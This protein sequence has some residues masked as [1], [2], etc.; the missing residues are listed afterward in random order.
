MRVRAKLPSGE[1]LAPVTGIHLDA[2]RATCDDRRARARTRRPLPARLHVR[3]EISY[4]AHVV[5]ACRVVAPPDRLWRQQRFAKP[6]PPTPTGSYTLSVTPSPVTVQ[7]GQSGT[8]TINIARTNFAAAVNLS[9]SAPNGITATLAS[10]STTANS[11][12]ITLAVASTVAAGS[13]SVTISGSATGVATQTATLAVTVTGAPAPGSFTMTAAPNPLSVVAGASGTSTIT[14]GR[15]LFT[16]DITI[17]ATASPGLTAT[18]TGSPASGTSASVTVAAAATA[19]G[20]Y[21][22]TL[23]GTGTGVTSQTVT[24][25][26]TVTAA[27]SGSVAVAVSPT[28]ATVQ[29]GATSTPVTVTITRTNLTGAVSVAVEGLPAGVTAAPATQEIAANATSAT[30]TLTAA[31]S[32]NVGT[33][34]YT[35]RAFNAGAANLGTG[36]AQVT[37]SAAAAG[38]FTLSASPSPLTIAA[39]GNGTLTVAITRTNFTGAV[40]LAASSTGGLTTAVTGSPT[41]GNS[42]TI[43]VTAPAGTAA[44]NYT[45][46]I[47]G[48]AAG[49]AAQTATATVTV[50]PSGGGGGN[51]TFVF[52]GNIPVWFAV[53]DGT[54]AWTR[55]LPTGNRFQFNINSAR[56][57]VAY[58]EQVANNQFSTDVFYGTREE[59]NGQGTLED[60]T[61]AGGKTVNGTIT[62]FTPPQQVQI[63]MGGGSASP[64]A[65]GAFTLQNVEN[66]LVDLVAVRTN[67]NLTTFSFT[68][69]RF[70]IRRN[71]NP[72]NGSTLAPL[73]FGSSEAFAPAEA[74]LTIGNA[75]SDTSFVSVGYY[76]QNG[77]TS[78]FF[79]GLPTGGNTRRMFGVPA[80]QQQ[81]NEFHQ[82]LIF[83]GSNLND[84]QNNFRGAFFFFR[85]MADR[86]VTLANNLNSPNVSSLAG[87]ASGRVRAVGTLNAPYTSAVSLSVQQTTSVRSV[88][89]NA[90]AGYLGGTA[91]DLAVPDFTGVAGWLDSYGLVRGQAAQ[92]TVNGFGFTGAGFELRPTEGA[93]VQ[94]G[95]RGGNVTP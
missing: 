34:S 65:P 26:V 16:G 58:T 92:W 21:T 10:T 7:A 32:A 33:A 50:S 2:A 91:Y 81:A 48:T 90:T 93:L 82:V 5:R 1:R 74:N 45:L 28:P 89:I 54:G 12:G 14:L 44:G 36:N 69:D 47:A 49:A 3:L 80:A 25:G 30:F 66:G 52:C 13:Y 40:T 37:I 42:A 23:T 53:Q 18:V 94:L 77:S 46:T 19:P 78:S 55:V 8:S 9:A 41:T 88:F 76:T 4:E 35:V 84:L 24:L 73:D 86:T 79:S 71:L 63:G 60:C 56:G 95:G 62:G 75:G 70:I 27:A 22:V 59:L 31:A 39:G 67:I 57:G 11:V 6:A 43:T 85:T 20:N 61:T 83:S 51:T 68:P 87:G 17:A 72:A 64:Q 15:I 38:S 29:Q